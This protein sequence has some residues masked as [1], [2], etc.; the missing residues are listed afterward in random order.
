MQHTKDLIPM[1]AVRVIVPTLNASRYLPRLL[2]GLAKQPIARD[3]ILFIDSSSTD[4]TR[5]QCE[6][7]GAQFVTIDRA[8]FNH[9]G[10]RARA[11]A[12]FPEATVF[13]MMTHDAISVDET[14]LP[15]IVAAF[16]DPEVGMAYGRQLPRPGA[17][18]IERFS[19]LF[20]YGEHSAVRS[21]ADAPTLGVKTTFCSNSFAAYRA[22]A[23]HQVGGFPID[24]FFAEDQITAG[25]MILAGWKLAY[26]ADAQVFHSHDY[27]VREDFNRYFDVGVFHARNPWLHEQFGSAESEGMR[28][29]RAE[30]GYLA[31]HDPAQLPSAIART[32]A[33]YIGYK[34]GRAEQRLSNAAKAKLSMQ[35]LYWRR[36]GVKG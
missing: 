20:N 25:K 33:K 31:A 4:D 28:F 6:S 2:E 1:T 32:F 35:P 24:A 27:S 30:T 10:T 5:A 16:A 23:Y 17:R 19:R 26:R 13:V 22:T 14:T 7:F 29:L 21:L 18:G 15:N 12:M 34:L 3:Q 9:G 11:I 8:E 36:Q